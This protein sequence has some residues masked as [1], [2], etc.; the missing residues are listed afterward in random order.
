MRL[1]FSNAVS[2]AMQIFQSQKEQPATMDNEESGEKVRPAAREPG[3]GEF[4]KFPK[5]PHFLLEKQNHNRCPPASQ[6]GEN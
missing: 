1:T 4:T 3:C 2:D 6:A 5:V